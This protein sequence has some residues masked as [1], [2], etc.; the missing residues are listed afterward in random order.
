MAFPEFF[1]RAQKSSHTLGCSDIWG[2][3]EGH[4][5]G[6]LTATRG[7]PCSGR[8]QHISWVQIPQHEGADGRGGGTHTPRH[9]MAREEAG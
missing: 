7:R 6:W 4:V 9:R 8:C 1:L 5:V 3:R 2:I